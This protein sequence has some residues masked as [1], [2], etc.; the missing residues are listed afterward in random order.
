MLFLMSPSLHENIH[1]YYYYESRVYRSKD[2]II[3]SRSKTLQLH[4]SKTRN[5]SVAGFSDLNINI[6]KTGL[7]RNKVVVYFDTVQVYNLRNPEY[8]MQLTSKKMRISA[9]IYGFR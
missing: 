3:I 4:L 5:A 2:I 1:Y 7:S 9:K 8:Y 6:V